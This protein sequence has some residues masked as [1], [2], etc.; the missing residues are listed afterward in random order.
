MATLAECPECHK[1]QSIRN[2][3]CAC[4]EN[5]DNAKRCKEK[6]KYWINFRLPNGKQR[7]EFIGYSVEEARDA[8]GKRRVQKRENRIFDMLPEAEKTFQELSDW[9]LG[10]EKVKVLSSF[11][12]VELSLKKFN[13]EFGNIIV[14]N[15]RPVDLENY[16]MKRRAEGKADST[17]DQEV[18][19]A[20]T[21]II[22]AFDN[23]L[24]GGH[25]LKTFK[26]VKKLLKANA[27]ARDRI[28]S[29][30]EFKALC[31]NSSTTLIKRII[32]T[33]YWSGMRSGEIKNLKWNRVDM[34]KR[35]IRLRAEDTKNG[36]PRSVPIGKALYRILKSIPRKLHNDHVFFSDKYGKPV[37]DIRAS[38]KKTCED[39]GILYGRF[40]EGGFV[41]HDLRHTFNT[42][43]RKAGVQESVIMSIMGHELPGMFNRYNTVDEEDIQKAME[44]LEGYIA[45]VDQTVDQMA[46]NAN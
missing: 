45:S 34:K 30:E 36:R 15:L 27:N 38:L 16:Q 18:G 10:L 26:V 23:G 22:K 28:L 7:R 43:M 21:V 4:G 12:R 44:Q 20:R 2:K 5:L 24:I 32:V 9:H 39:A 14:G 33:G 42:N 13:S 35:I 25:T 19:A 46:K 40:V 8:D 41:F 31:D 11:W 37:R 3:I 6:V 17:I 1:K 29:T